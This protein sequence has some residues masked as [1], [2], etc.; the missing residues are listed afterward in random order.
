MNGS[1]CGVKH[2]YIYLD[3]SGVLHKDERNKYFVYGGYAFWGSE[4]EN[5]SRK[6]KSLENKIRKANNQIGELKAFTLTEKKHKNALYKVLRDYQKISLCVDIGRIYDNITKNK[7]SIH[8][9][10]DWIVKM[11]IK[12]VIKK[13]INNG[14]I[15]ENE[16][17]FLHVSLDEQGTKTNGIYSLERSIEE[18]LIN[19]INNFDYGTFF[20]PVLKGGFTLELLYCDSKCNALIRASDILANRVWVSYVTNKPELRSLPRHIH[21][22]FP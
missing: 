3:D 15:D 12:D 1:V 21:K 13:A 18:E 16:D 9:Y 22:I 5:A 4:K 11:L 20:P 10:K 19:G 14:K 17:I 6:Y 8:R 2:I 7:D